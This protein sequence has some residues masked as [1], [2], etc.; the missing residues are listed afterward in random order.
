MGWEHYVGLQGR[1]IGLSHFGASA[2]GA[3]LYEEFGLTAQRVIEEATAT[4]QQVK[5]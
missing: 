4:L 3:T 5:A 2:S 1:I